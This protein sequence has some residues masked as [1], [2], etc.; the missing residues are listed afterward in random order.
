MWRTVAKVAATLTAL[1]ALTLALAFR[2]PAS[3]LYMPDTACRPD[4]GRYDS[5]RTGSSYAEV[6]AHMGCPGIQARREQLGDIAIVTYVWRAD[7]WPVGIVRLAFY[8]DTLQATSE[9]R[10]NLWIGRH[11]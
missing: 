3:P 11:K 9:T 2:L 5:L 1:L 4:K 8:N 6:S 10:L 7:S